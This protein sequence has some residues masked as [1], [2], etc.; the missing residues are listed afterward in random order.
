MKSTKKE[1]SKSNDASLDLVSEEITKLE[2]EILYSIKD[3]FDAPF[4]YLNVSKPKELVKLLVAFKHMSPVEYENGVV[5]SPKDITTRYGSSPESMMSEVIDEVLIKTIDDSVGCG[6]Y[7][8][9]LLHSI[10]NY[11]ELD[12]L[13]SLLTY[14]FEDEDGIDDNRYSHNLCNFQQ[15]HIVRM[16][17]KGG[18]ATATFGGAIL[19]EIHPKYSIVDFISVLTEELNKVSLKFMRDTMGIS[20]GSEDSWL[21]LIKAENIS[22]ALTSTMLNGLMRANFGELC[23][24]SKT[25]SGRNRDSKEPAKSRPMGF[26]LDGGNK[27]QLSI[28]SEE[29]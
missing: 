26:V 6:S 16:V 18:E 15:P 4:K 11:L 8:V 9:A 24:K 27:S 7:G 10:D 17:R 19:S 12:F 21:G 3:A 13:K 22:S 23:K 29:S 28:N 1:S 25:S 2:E 14:T 5:I 20:F